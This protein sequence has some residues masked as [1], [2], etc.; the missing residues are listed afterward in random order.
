MINRLKFKNGKQK[1]KITQILLLTLNL[2]IIKFTL[3]YYNLTT[4]IRYIVCL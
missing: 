1:N 3:L 2:I 4:Q